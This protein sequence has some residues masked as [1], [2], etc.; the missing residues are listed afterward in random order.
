MWS[1]IKK[2]WR[3]L[4]RGPP[5]RRFQERYERN[6]RDRASRSFAGRYLPPAI[7]LVLLAAG[8][9]FSI[10]PGPGLPLLLVGGGLLAGEFSGVARVL[11]WC[12]VRLR[13]LFNR[14]AG[15]WK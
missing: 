9:A 12:E 3:Q 2:K 7:G 6:Q 14:V 4:R 1:T 13:K 5:G 8:V 11:D 10:L 15:W